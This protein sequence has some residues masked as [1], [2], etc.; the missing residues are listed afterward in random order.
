[1]FKIILKHALI[2]FTLFWVSGCNNT[3]DYQSLFDKHY[4]PF[5]IQLRQNAEVTYPILDT[6]YQAYLDEDY[7]TVDQLTTQF[8]DEYFSVPQVMFAQTIAFVELHKDE[9]AISNFKT[10]AMH[11]FLGASAKWYRGLV[12]LR[13]GELDEAKALFLEVRDRTYEGE[14][15][16]AK[17]ILEDLENLDL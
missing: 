7:E 5:E 14:K 10:L 13:R 16:W 2:V 1:M 9:E 8:L 4:E 17:S 15:E 12:H 3:P 11:P 6:A